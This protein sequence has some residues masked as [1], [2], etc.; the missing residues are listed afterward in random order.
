MSYSIK[1][2]EPF[3]FNNSSE[4]S[5]WIR[6]FERYRLASKLVEQGFLTGGKFTPPGENFTYQGGKFSESKTK[7]T[8]SF[9]MEKAVVVHWG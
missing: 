9:G 8:L 1:S 6:R 3:N 7:K 4:W 5:N 2:P